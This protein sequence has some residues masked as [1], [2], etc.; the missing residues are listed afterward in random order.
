[1]TLYN[2][3]PYKCSSTNGIYRFTPPSKF[4]FITNFVINNDDASFL[5]LL[6]SICEVDGMKKCPY[7]AEKIQDEAIV[8]RYCGR[9]LPASLKPSN[10]QKQKSSVSGQAAKVAAI[11]TLLGAIGIYF[12]YQNEPAE[13]IGSL[14]LGSVGSF[15]IW[16][17][18]LAGIISI[19]RK[20]GEASGGRTFLIIGIIILVGAGGVVLS[21]LGKGNTFALR[22]PTPVPVVIY[23]DDFSNNQSGWLQSNDESGKFQYS[24]GQYVIDLPAGNYFN[25]ACANRNFTDEVIS[26][27]AIYIS[28]DATEGG[29]Y[30]V[31]RYTDI[32]NFYSLFFSGGNN[33]WVFKRIKGQWQQFGT[34]FAPSSGPVNAEQQVNNITIS[35]KGAISNIYLNGKYLT[36]INDSTFSNGD[37]CLGASSSATSP[38]AVSFDNLVVYSINSWTPPNP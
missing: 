38:S 18:V 32:N 21:S 37:I 27:D 6:Y 24:G 26:V 20:A 9:D 31:W 14:T 19:W 8:C 5:I 15:F 7:C 1:M 30:I 23:S 22:V 34:T 17:L 33:L 29:P 13:L 28:G 12:T 35:V 11:L 36:N 2:V 16:W 3:K 25:L 10:N 4:N